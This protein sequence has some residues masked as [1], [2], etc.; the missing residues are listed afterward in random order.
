MTLF[1]LAVNAIA[2]TRRK[3]FDLLAEEPVGASCS[4]RVILTG[5][6]P[7]STVERQDILS[8]LMGG[9]HKR[10]PLCHYNV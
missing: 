6:L 2:C 5:I 8:P 4:Q 7:N 10:Y 1:S 9:Q 3:S